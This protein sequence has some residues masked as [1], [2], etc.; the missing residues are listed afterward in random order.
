MTSL[1]S[2]LRTVMMAV[3]FALL[4][5]TVAN[6]TSTVGLYADE[7]GATCSFSGNQQ[8]ALTAYVVV[9]PDAA[10]IR[11]VRFMAPPPPCLGATWVS[12]STPPYAVSIG[13]SET[14]ISIAF[15][16]C[17]TEPLMALTIDYYRTST[18]PCCEFV[19]QPYAGKIEGIDC[20]Y[21]QATMASAT[22]KF[23]ADAS[24]PCADGQ[25][26]YP[27]TS[28]SP[29]D[30]ATWVGTSDAL[31]WAYSPFDGDIVSSDVYL[32][33]T[34]VPPLVATV[35]SPTW[36]PPA[37]LDG[38]TLY[39]WRVVLHDAE[40][41]ATYGPLWRFT[42]RTGNS[43]PSAPTA[44]VPATFA[45]NV[46]L[47]TTL[48]W[49]CS[50]S[51]GDALRYY[52][53]FGTVNPP[54]LAASLLNFAR[55]TPAT[56][57]AN[58]QYYWYVVARDSYGAETTGPVWT[59]TTGA[60]I[61]HPPG[62]P[63]AVSPA[64][65]AINV[66]FTT[67]L[68]WNSTDVDGDPITFSVYFGTVSPPPLVASDV[69]LR[70]YDP[71]NLAFDTVHYWRIVARDSHG[72]ETSGPTWVFR[73]QLNNPPTLTT[74]SPPNGAT[75]VVLT[76]TLSWQS[77]D[78][79]PGST[80]D[81]CFGTTSPPPVV[82][83]NLTTTSYAPGTLAVETGYFWRVIAH[84]AQG[85]TRT[86]S[87]WAF[88]T[89]MNPTPSNPSPGDNTY[90]GASVTLRWSTSDPGIYP[91][92][93]DLYF[94]TQNPPPL[95][96]S[97]I[98][99]SSGYTTFSYAAPG[100]LVYGTRYYWRVYSY[101]VNGGHMG[102]V[103]SF[104]AEQLGDV[105]R[106][107]AITLADA[108][109]ALQLALTNTSCAAA[110]A[111]PLADVNCVAGVTPRDALCIHRKAIGQS[112]PFCG[113]TL[114][115]ELS[116][117]APFLTRS[118]W[119][120]TGDI[121]TFRLAVSGVSSLEAFSF[122]VQKPLNL[123]LLSALRVGATG[124]Y[125]ALEYFNT[126]SMAYVGGYTLE[127][128]AAVVTTEFIEL[129]FQ[130]GG[131]LM[132]TVTVTG[133]GDDLSGGNNLVLASG[134]GKGGGGLPVLFTRFNAT[135][136]QGGVRIA[137]EFRHDDALDGYTIYRGA[138]GAAPTLAVVEGPADI[139]GSYLDR[140]IE[141]GKLYRYEMVV[142]ASDGDEYRSPIATVQVPG[143]E[144]SLGINHPN[145][146]NPQTTIPY[147]LP[148]GGAPVRVRLAIYDTSGHLVRVLVD[149][150][151]SGGAREVV[152]RGEDSSGRMVTSGVYFCVLQVDNDRRTRKLV[153]LK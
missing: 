59:F 68:G 94:G 43:A 40:G 138:D 107:G 95:L 96:A 110:N 39:Y 153:L 2:G 70:T 4:P 56:M 81:V 102:P 41:L 48:S 75:N 140:A 8:G 51:D 150:D 50:D 121:V 126:S 18:T 135:A 89:A 37:A 139:A 65:N 100:D 49:Q 16:Y 147:N 113:Q 79:F 72:L 69:T 13:A 119:T 128:V 103:W 91:I 130:L 106:D 99:A 60:F 84:D 117:A 98:G 67:D 105:N 88:S 47:Q 143:L 148:P 31:S 104:T 115:A 12:E 129:R 11:G 82:A 122:A 46:G 44:P 3:F 134:S 32:G 132:S 35:S 78:E 146:F 127:P 152:W 142:R 133:Y 73:T 14:D 101:N 25:A 87:I 54:P 55:Y 38:N 42:T 116:P 61:N 136:E 112:C 109:C 53:Y 63:T 131:Q 15:G 93:C 57:T 77:T 92:F 7:N 23:N 66:P 144:L 17:T 5:S 123:T 9:K 22:A 90:A 64:N 58:T 19:I 21:G 24:C 74:P 52:V 34:T 27:P 30:Y 62:A 71:G 33:K 145:P 6:A 97:A 118:L 149:E 80:F 20:V 124:D 141:P 137:W 83:S 86:G 26:P 76:P 1:R 151:Q 85:N 114:A 36:Q 111:L 108:A 120:Q 125:T 10:G 28:P 29:A 45:T